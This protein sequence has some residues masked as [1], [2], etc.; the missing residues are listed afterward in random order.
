MKSSKTID[1]LS[2]AFVAAQAELKN[3]TFDKVNPHFKSKYA[4]LA[5]VRDT[6]T[7]I[8]AKHGLAVAQGTALMGEAGYAVITRLMHNSGQWI[9]S[10]YPFQTDKPQQMGSAYT[11]ARRYSL[12]A[13]C[14]IASEEDDDANTAQVSS[15]KPVM[16]TVNG[17]AG[18]SKAFN[19]GTYD[20]MVKEIRDANGVKALETWYQDNVKTLDAMPPDWL[21]ELRIEYSDKISELKKGLAA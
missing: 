11:Y 3:A 10:E 7:P 20:I 8:L 17:T 19:R 18:A 4:T 12:A 21:D 1:K 13:I 14:G 9:E 15:P 2:A 6:I 16:A 5:G